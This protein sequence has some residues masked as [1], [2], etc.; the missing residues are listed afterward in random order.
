MLKTRTST[1]S[2]LTSS[3][4]PKRMVSWTSPTSL[5]HRRLRLSKSHSKFH[6][7]LLSPPRVLAPSHHYSAPS[8]SLRAC[9]G[10]LLFILQVQFA[11]KFLKKSFLTQSSLGSILLS[12]FPSFFSLSLP[13]LISSFSFCSLLA[14]IHNSLKNILISMYLQMCTIN[15]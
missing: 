4:S 1:Y 11:T 2:I 7:P 6:R 3:L 15:S 14:V 9:P 8:W 12:S 5:S 10:S 13:F